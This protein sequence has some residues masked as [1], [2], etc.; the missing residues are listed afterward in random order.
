M[1]EIDGGADRIGSERQQ[2]IPEPQFI[3]C[4]RQRKYMVERLNPQPV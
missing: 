3:F 4:K 1:P 2:L